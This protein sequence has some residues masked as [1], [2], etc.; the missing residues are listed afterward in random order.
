MCVE[1]LD[2]RDLEVRLGVLRRAVVDDVL[3]VL[4][5]GRRVSGVRREG[6]KRGEKA[7]GEKGEE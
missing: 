7:G 4:R 1:R 3:E 6:G 5:V 2:V